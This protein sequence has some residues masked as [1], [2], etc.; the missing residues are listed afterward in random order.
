MS[1]GPFIGQETSASYVLCIPGNDQWCDFPLRLMQS[2]PGYATRFESWDDAEE[3]AR[4]MEA[5]G[6]PEIE[7]HETEPRSRNPSCGRKNCGGVRRKLVPPGRPCVSG[8]RS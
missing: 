8:G 1:A 2:F 4:V 6:W 3:A 7:I 5:H